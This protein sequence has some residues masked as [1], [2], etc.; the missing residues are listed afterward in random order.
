MHIEWIHLKR[1]R[2]FADARI[3]L[4]K[5]TLIIGANDVGKTNLLYA[6]RILLDRSLPDSA[7]DPSESD[8][9]VTIADQTQADDCEITIK[10]VEIDKDPILAS[11]KGAVSDDGESYLSYRAKK[12]D[13]SH[14]L[15][16]GASE[17]LLEDIPSRHYL[18]FVNLRYVQSQRDLAHFVQYEKRAL[19]KL[20]KE[21]RQAAQT[22]Q[23]EILLDEI[24]DKLDEVN[25]EIRKLNYVS[26]ATA[27]VNTELQEL[28]HHHGAYEVR[29]ETGAIHTT[30]FIDQLELAGISGGARLGLGGD[31]RN[32]QILMALW[33]AKSEREQDLD[34]E[35]I[36]FC[37]E[38]PEAHLHPHQQRKLSE[39]LVS[40]LKGQVLVTSHSPQIAARFS[41]NS[42]VRLLSKSA[43][44]TAASQGCSQCI[45]NAWTQMG[46]RLSI[47]PAE[48]FFA[49]LVFL[50]EGPSEILFYHELA[51]QL[52]IDLDR[53]NIS[54]LSVDGIDFDAFIT[55]LNAMEIPWVVRTDND[56]FK[57]QHSDPP[58]RRLAGLNRARLIIGEP[59]Y[60]HIDQ[61]FTQVAH[62][63]RWTE[64]AALANPRNVFVS[65]V[66][67]ETDL[68]RALPAV[69]MQFA[70]SDTQEDAIKYFQERKAIH[71]GDFLRLH[72]A[73]LQGLAANGLA[74]PLQKCAQLIQAPAPAPAA[75]VPAAPVSAPAVAKNSKPVTAKVSK[76]VPVAATPAAAAAKKIVATPSPAKFA[77]PT[78]APSK[79]KPTPRTPR[80]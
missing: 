18:R 51:R 72:K 63:T 48:A 6:L 20:S 16:V 37:I 40:K 30:Q 55:I 25:S 8:F 33:K 3:N 45:Q 11:L 60:P 19:L 52:N 56:V 39:Y 74:R 59:Q 38:E 10:F 58:K 73:T 65:R 36:I 35:C 66:D 14:S 34:N 43:K 29:L 26:S 44:T 49:D 2:N 22:E 42:I 67:L 15:H 76:P 23:D 28:S 47:L 24:G 78:P 53:L 32:N 1:Y 62:D 50:V 41:P 57:V 61:T 9:H 7:L 27:A 70:E 21:A 71:M 31:G 5:G 4:E 77:T 75:A 79:P 13:L 64:T 12:A 17:E 46:Y 80:E 69:C 54:I 68:V